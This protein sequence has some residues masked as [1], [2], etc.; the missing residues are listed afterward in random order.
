[1][2]NP[3]RSS[4]LE[5]IIRRVVLD[6]AIKHDGKAQL[7]PVLG[8]LIGENPDLRGKIKEVTS[9]IVE[10]L[11]EINSLTLKEQIET[12]HRLWPELLEREKE[13]IEEEKRLPPL[14]NVN[15]YEQIVTRFAPN[16]DL[17]L[18]HI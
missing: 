14:P 6:N 4:R 1:M 8:R 3:E 12:A 15:K 18:I 13:R 5:E 17:S 2:N 16:P 11:E 7:K 9:L 10:I